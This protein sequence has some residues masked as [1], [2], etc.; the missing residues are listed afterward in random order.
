LTNRHPP[1][2]PFPL[3][4]S[5]DPLFHHHHHHH[6]STTDGTASSVRHRQC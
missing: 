4:D 1:I 6:Q 2:L 3:P 5:V